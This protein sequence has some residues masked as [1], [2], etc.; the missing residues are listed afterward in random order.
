MVLLVAVAEAKERFPGLARTTRR[1]CARGGGPVMSANALAAMR[2]R[3]GERRVFAPALQSSR[4]C[5]SCNSLF[6]SSAT[7]PPVTVAPMTV[8]APNQLTAVATAGRQRRATLGQC[9]S[10]P[11]APAAAR[12]LRGNSSVGMYNT[13]EASSESLDLCILVTS[14]T[15]RSMLI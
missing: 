10:A 1:R 6:P 13:C 12:K 2:V 7:A 3:S 9:S 14:S 4:S 8:A 5:T 11:L 15:F